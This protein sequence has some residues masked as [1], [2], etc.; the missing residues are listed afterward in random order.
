[1]APRPDLVVVATPSL[2]EGPTT[3]ASHRQ[4]HGLPE[5]DKRKREKKKEGKEGKEGKEKRTKEK[6]LKITKIININA[7]CAR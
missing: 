6:I 1:M 2:G 5:R 7:G 4:G 3:S